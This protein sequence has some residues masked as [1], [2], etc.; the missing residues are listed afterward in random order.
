[1]TP[2]GF[3]QLPP[4]FL[5]GA[6]PH[7]LAVDTGFFIIFIFIVSNGGYEATP[8]QLARVPLLVGGSILHQRRRQ[9]LSFLLTWGYLPISLPPLLGLALPTMNQFCEWSHSSWGLL[10]TSINGY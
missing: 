6:H 4:L 3:L 9:M 8:L 10:S 2:R 5:G 1:M 7:A